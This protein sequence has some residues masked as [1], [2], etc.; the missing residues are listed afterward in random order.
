MIVGIT[1]RQQ[2]NDSMA[3]WGSGIWTLE[4]QRRADVDQERCVSTSEEKQR[5]LLHPRTDH[6][7][8]LCINDS[9]FIDVYAQGSV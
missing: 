9:S 5:A 1:I 8:G 7:S 3:Q 6:Q 4:A 2:S